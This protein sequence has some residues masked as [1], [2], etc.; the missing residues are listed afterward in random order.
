MTIRKPELTFGIEIELMDFWNEKPIIAEVFSSVAN[1]KDRTLSEKAILTLSAVKNQK[2]WD[3][4]VLEGVIVEDFRDMKPLRQID[5]SADGK[6]LPPW[7]ENIRKRNTYRTEIRKPDSVLH[8]ATALLQAN[9]L[10]EWKAV[11]DMS[12]TGHGIH[13]VELVSPVLKPEDFNSIEKICEIFSGI[14]KIDRTC[15]LHVHIGQGNLGFQYGHVK[16]L[17]ER[18]METEPLVKDHPFYQLT[19]YQNHAVGS[20]TN[21]K[22]VRKTTNL[23]ELQETVNPDYHRHWLINLW[24]LN[25]YETIEFRG[26]KSTL[27]S[28]TIKDAVRFCEQ[29][30]RESF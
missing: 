1:K 10:H 25:T 3:L 8:Q 24:A 4:K 22:E 16:R 5:V 6:I 26:F 11:S 23:Q 19:G 2:G 12:V 27:D 30:V 20:V 17:I 7:K 15:G 18:W 9:Q 13:A 29:Q 21:L 14:T 28:E